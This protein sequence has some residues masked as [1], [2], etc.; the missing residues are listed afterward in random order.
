[1]RVARRL[2]GVVWEM[3]CKTLKPSKNFKFFASKVNQF[4]RSKE[5]LGQRGLNS[6]FPKIIAS[7]DT[8]AHKIF[9][10]K[11]LAKC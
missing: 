3:F 7:R 6:E 1:M 11:Q 2:A 8:I 10:I 4:W 9:R 5:K